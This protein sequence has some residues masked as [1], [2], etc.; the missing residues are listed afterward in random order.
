M[1]RKIKREDKEKLDNFIK[2]DIYQ[3]VYLYIDTQ[4]YGYE[5]ENIETYILEENENIKIILYTYYNSLQLFQVNPV[6]SE[7]QIKDITNYINKNQ[8]NMVSANADLAKKISFQLQG[9]YEFSKG[10]VMCG[11][12]VNP[13]ESGITEWANENQCDEIAK[14]ICSDAN[15]GGHYMVKEL[16][17]QLIDRLRNWHCRNL[18]IK[19]DR[20]IVAHMATYAEKNDVAVLG[21]LITDIQYRG[22]G[23]GKKVLVDLTEAILKEEKTPIIFVFNE[24]LVSWYEN[25]GWEIVNECGK[26]EYISK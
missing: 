6:I 21:G 14:L 15:I 4:T 10:V 12:K 8:F 22:N 24:K 26:L 5:S 17:N 16:S 25:I 3:N 20:K 18:I 23:Y 9:K 2:R 19:K 7:N 1:I 11:N 13:C